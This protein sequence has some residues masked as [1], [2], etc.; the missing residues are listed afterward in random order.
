VIRRKYVVLLLL[1][2]VSIPLTALFYSNLAQAQATTTG[3]VSV[4]AAAF[5]PQRT[6][7]DWRNYGTELENWEVSGVATYYAGLQLPHGATI[8]NLTSYWYDDSATNNVVC[9]IWRFN[10]TDTNTVTVASGDVSD[11]PGL[12]SYHATTMF[13]PTVDNNNYTYFMFVYLPAPYAN[14]YF[15]YA[16][17]EYTLPSGG[18]G[19]FWIPVDKF[20]LLAPYIALVATVILAVSITVAIIKHRKK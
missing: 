6:D 2:L 4:P 10:Q 1:T 13:Y 19:G 17:V 20:S 8:M 12:G 7:M 3:Y 14:Y 5:T 15:Q 9:G 11:A 18:V 16:I